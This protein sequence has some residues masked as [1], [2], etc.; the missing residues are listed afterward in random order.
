MLTIIEGSRKPT[1]DVIDGVMQAD[2]TLAIQS[3]LK[4]LQFSNLGLSPLTIEKYT[5]NLRAYE[6]WLGAA[7]P[8]SEDSAQS[9]LNFLQ[10][11]GFSLATVQ[12][13]YHA[14]KPFL[15]YIGIKFIV[16]FK[17]RK[18][19]PTYHGI[20]QVKAILSAAQNRT[21]RWGK[22]GERDSLIILMFAYTGLRRA[23]L[24]S[25][26][27]RDINFYTRM[28]RVKGKGNKE[29]IIPIAACLYEKLQKYTKKMSITDHLFPIKF[30][31][32]NTMI[33]NYARQ[34]GI[35]DF[36]CHSFRHYFATQ[37]IENGVDIKKVQELLGHSDI[38][39]T[40]IYL[41]CIP[42]HLTDAVQHLPN[43][44]EK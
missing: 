16:K 29:R 42:K 12:S 4:H 38:S 32:I 5:Q 7:T 18:Y 1:V 36:T 10:E 44:M 35:D 28:I 19:L 15:A 14:L 21:D 41:D 2:I 39:T 17:K 33:R 22:L 34:V 26:T 31:R 6:K 24:L 11:R 43:L 37:L 3:Y 30:T 9:F 20:D 13:Y 8:I 23:E 40:S 27:V 25:L